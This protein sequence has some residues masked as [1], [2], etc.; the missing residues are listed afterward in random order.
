MLCWWESIAGN[1]V[2][3]I[4]L[5]MWIGHH[6]ELKADIS[7]IS[8]SS[9]QLMRCWCSK[10]QPFNSLWWPILYSKCQIGIRKQR[11]L[12]LTKFCGKNAMP[13]IIIYILHTLLDTFPL[14]LIR[15]ICSTIK[16]FFCWYHFL[17]SCDLNVGFR[18]D[19]V[20]TI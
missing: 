6:K 5:K 16:R 7:S 20:R 8:P 15:R 3:T 13:N 14:V 12:W 18:E 11:L 1:L 10:C 19:I 17:Y 2:L 4:E 9:E